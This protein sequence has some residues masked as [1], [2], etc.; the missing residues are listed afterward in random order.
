MERRDFLV[1]NLSGASLGLAATL[2][3]DRFGRKDAA[4][5]PAPTPGL[6]AGVQASFAQQGEDLVVRQILNEVLKIEHPS[7]IDIG[8]WDPIVD[9]NTYLF[10]LTGGAGVLVEP[11]PQFAERLKTVRPRDTVL[12]I[13]I[14]V[15]DQTEADYYV[16]AIPQTNTF[17]KEQADKL[18]AA[19]GKQFL[20]EVI[21]LPLVN[22]NRVLAEN[23]ETAPNFFSIDIEGLDLEILKT[24]DFGRFRPQV[25]CVETIET[26]S[27]RFETEVVDFMRANDY[28]WRGGSFVNS[29]FIDR[30]IVRN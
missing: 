8:A 17:S 15:T 29:I 12:G 25:F 1:G 20:K 3:S 13:G 19:A 28:A 6:P 24:L 9:S 26:V 11:N 7:Y 14:G 27:R 16:M 18:V 10:Y 2:A 23:F 5:A 4:K 30:R 22:V 21:K